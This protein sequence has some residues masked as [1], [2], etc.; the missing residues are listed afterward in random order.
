M[1]GAMKW[2]VVAAVVLLAVAAWARWRA[3]RGRGPAPR[4]DEI[5]WAEVPYADGTGAKLRPCLVRRRTWRGVV[6]LKIT[7]QDKRTRRDHIAIPTKGWDPRARSDSYLNLAEPITVRRSAF[8]R[9][10]GT[11]DQVTLSRIARADQP[12]P[13]RAPETVAPAPRSP[14]QRRTRRRIR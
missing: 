5:W 8:K 2:L 12:G 11:A 3:I 4:R 6:V 13:T 1:T 9:R 10:A 7:S 14:E